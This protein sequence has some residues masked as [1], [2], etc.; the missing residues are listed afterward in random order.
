[1][2]RLH[3]MWLIMLWVMATGL[4][5]VAQ[6]STAMPVSPGVVGGEAVVISQDCPT[7]SWSQIQEAAAYKLR[8]YE[9]A[10]TN[11]PLE[12]DMEA[13]AQ[14]VISVDIPGPA[15]S[16]TTSKGRCLDNG[17]TYVW[18]VQAL[19][20]ANAA[21]SQGM[22]FKVDLTASVAMKETVQSTIDNYI[23][24][25]LTKTTYYQ[26]FRDGIKTDV[27][28]EVKSSGI[29]GV[30]SALS[31]ESDANGNAYFGTGAGTNLNTHT[32]YNSFFGYN[33]G[34]S[35]GTGATSFVGNNT[36]VGYYAGQWITTGSK[37][38][39]IGASAGSSAAAPSASSNVCIGYL[40]CNAGSSNTIV[41]TNAGTNSTG[42]N[43]VFIGYRAG[44]SETDSNKLYLDNCYASSSPNLCD[45]PLIK[46]DFQGRSVQIDG[47]LT[48][49]TV[50]T[51]SDIRY[52]KDIQPLES[53][54]EKVMHL[55]GV[56]YAWDKSA[57]QGAGYG[58]GRQIGFIAQEMEQVIP[59][60]VQT[61]TKG[62]KTLSYDKLVP[63]L[64]EAI[65]EQQE[66]TS[67]LRKENSEKESRIVQLEK[68]FEQMEK[69]LTSL[70]T[71]AKTVAMK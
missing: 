53:S 59:E 20:E 26:T 17:K 66:M 9:M 14:P 31:N 65:K 58:E 34:Y 38:T 16:W 4:A 11:M 37:N 47:T 36:F 32:Y 61:D 27:L 43:N 30:K 24:N 52:K 22:V 40:S 8:V 63:V 15:L 39:S 54:L 64:V 13:I 35:T 46:G 12:T 44:Y 49:V 6:G 1:M 25:D 70:E 3:L 67:Q 42:S 50:A 56:S 60:L 55:K 48:M 29:P 2:K 62:Y 33:T 45:Q 23:Q 18:Y 68:A 5:G 28:K 21:W 71:P 7:F 57:V 19:S 51:P 69:R 10:T 41:G